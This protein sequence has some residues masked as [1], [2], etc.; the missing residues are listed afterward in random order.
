LPRLNIL[1]LLSSL[2]S[3]EER[4]VF[5]RFTD[6]LGNFEIFYPKKWRFDR[7]IAVVEG[8]YTVCFESKESRFSVSVDASLPQDFDFERYAKEE[9]EAPTSGIIASIKKR[10]FRSMPAYKREY[11]FSSGGKDYFGGGLMFF[12]GTTVFSLSWSALEKDREKQEAIFDHMLERLS[13]RRGFT[14]RK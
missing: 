5:S 11:A 8:K 13:L 2:F 3:R 1:D 7:D 14:L 12:T 4:V 6:P 9:L 10:R